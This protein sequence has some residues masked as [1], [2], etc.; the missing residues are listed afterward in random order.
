MCVY[1]C[2]RTCE[3]LSSACLAFGKEDATDQSEQEKQMTGCSSPFPHY[4]TS[5]CLQLTHKHART[6]TRLCAWPHT[7]TC[8]PQPPTL[9]SVLIW[10]YIGNENGLELW[11]QN[12]LYSTA[13]FCRVHINT[14]LSFR[15]VTCF[16]AWHVYFTYIHKYQWFKKILLYFPDHSIKMY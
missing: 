1:V 16:I 10:D 11:D 7:H 4:Y 3:S 15:F 9:C 5:S 2:A 8:S 13:V 12:Y 14:G 6:Y